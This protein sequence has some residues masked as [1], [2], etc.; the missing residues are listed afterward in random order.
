[1]TSRGADAVALGSPRAESALAERFT[2][3]PPDAALHLAIR[4]AVEVALPAAIVRRTDRRLELHQAAGLD[5][6]IAAEVEPPRQLG[7]GPP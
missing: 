7:D 6:F 1:M 4:D 2:R 3:L 5:A